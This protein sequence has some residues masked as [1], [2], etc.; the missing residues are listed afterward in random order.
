MFTDAEHT[1]WGLDVY[2]ISPQFSRPFAAL[3]IWVSLLAHGWDAYERRILQDIA[4][5]RYLRELVLDHPELEPMADSELS[6]TCFRF[7]PDGLAAGTDADE[8]LDLLN[9]R[10]MFDLQ[11][12]G[13]VFPSNAIVDERFALRSC[14]VNFR[15]EAD[16]VEQLVD[17]TIRL[18]CLLD[19]QLR[20]RALT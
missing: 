20:P 2:E 15:T 17:E 8:Y 14:I 7:V 18:G 6:I 9:E 1:K 10:I 12:G 11:L 5:T 4:L 19:T 16:N 3:K 13:K